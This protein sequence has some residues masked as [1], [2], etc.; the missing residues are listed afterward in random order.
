MHPGVSAFGYQCDPGASDAVG[1]VSVD[2]LA[3]KADAAAAR[4]LQPAD[5]AHGSCLAHA[6]ASQQRDD[7]PLRHT[8]IDAKQHLAGAITALQ[9]FDGEYRLV[10]GVAPLSSPR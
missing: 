1:R 8:E 9:A 4:R 5:R 2:P 3:A 7:L 10:H 6:V